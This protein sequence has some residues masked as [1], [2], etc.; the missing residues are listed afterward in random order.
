MHAE[1][2]ARSSIS[3]AQGTQFLCFLDYLLGG[4][5]ILPVF[6]EENLEDRFAYLEVQ[7]EATSLTQNSLRP[8]RGGYHQAYGFSG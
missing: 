8:T 6:E 2:L 4:Q 3:A 7:T 1:S 5:V